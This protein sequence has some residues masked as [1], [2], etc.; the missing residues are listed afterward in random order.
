[1]SSK[2]N[3]SRLLRYLITALIL[4]GAH[5]LRDR[6][7]GGGDTLDP[8]SFPTQTDASYETLQGCR[9]I[10]N[11]G[12]DGDSLRVRHQGKE[13]TFRL[14]FVDCPETSNRHPD[15]IDHQSRYFDNLSPSDTIAVGK[16]AKAFTLKLLNENPFAIQTRWESVMKS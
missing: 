8:T 12:N 14:Y 9:I 7:E 10:S 11:P 3:K 13:H 15:R 5:L 6:I 2:S 4:A 1:M 16:E